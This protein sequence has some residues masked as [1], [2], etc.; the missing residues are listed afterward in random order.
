MWWACFLRARYS[1]TLPPL[2]ATLSGAPH[3]T[4]LRPHSRIPST[5]KTPLGLG[6][7][8]YIAHKV[9]G[10]E[11]SPKGVACRAYIAHKVWGVG[12]T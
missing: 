5:I 11:F 8:V 12:T 1:C 9:W 7:W 3:P 2:P 10:V 4:T 6:C